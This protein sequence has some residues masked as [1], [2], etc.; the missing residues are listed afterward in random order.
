MFAGHETTATAISWAL[1]WI[2]RD[3][4]IY[5]HLMAELK[6]LPEK[7]DPI[8]ISRL[9]YLSAVC[10]EALRLYPVGILTFPRLVKERVQLGE[11]ILEPGTVVVGCIY[12]VHRR[13]DLYPNADKFQ[14]ERFLNKQF[15]PYEFMA[16]GGGARRCIG[17]A[18][19]QYEMKLSLASILSRHQLSLADR[20]PEKAQRRGVTLAPA[21][22]VQMYVVD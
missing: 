4:Q 17:E 6:N 3:R 1:Y 19:A 2:H 15:A 20:Q 14:P 18:L 11:Y 9:P 21:G 16:F 5:E 7:A 8:T 13:E 22:E 10:N 12:L